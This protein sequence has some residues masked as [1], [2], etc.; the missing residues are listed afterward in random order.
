M[1]GLEKRQHVLQQSQENLGCGA[2]S[3]LRNLSFSNRHLD[4]I[5]WIGI[6]QRPKLY[7]LTTLT[8]AEVLLQIGV[9]SGRLG[10]TRQAAD[11]QEKAKD[12]ITEASHIFHSLNQ[13]VKVFE[14][15]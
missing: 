2:T 3:P 11:A 4:N 13:Q 1:A 15:Q 10:S 7:K 6:G 8:T 5:L 9:L 12:L 14:A